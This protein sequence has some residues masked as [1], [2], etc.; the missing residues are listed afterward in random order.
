MFT[1]RDFTKFAIVCYERNLW[2][3]PMDRNPFQAGKVSQRLTF[4]DDKLVF[5]TTRKER[6][7]DLE[8]LFYLAKYARLHVLRKHEVWF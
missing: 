7:I 5:G 1:S 2:I 4:A 6:P 8:S 3:T